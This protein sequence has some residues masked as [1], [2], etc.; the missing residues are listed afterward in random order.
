METDQVHSG[1]GTHSLMK[2]DEQELYSESVAQ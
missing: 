1:H 2:F